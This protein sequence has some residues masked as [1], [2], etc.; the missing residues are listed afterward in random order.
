[1]KPFIQKLLEFLLFILVLFSGAGII[2]WSVN[3]AVRKGGYVS[4]DKGIKHVILGNSMPECAFN[5]QLVS[6]FKNLAQSGE[7]NFYT[8]VKTRQILLNNP[9]V[10]AVFIGI[11]LSL[12]DPK[13]WYQDNEALLWQ[14]TKYAPF[15]EGRDVA[16]LTIRNSRGSAK[17]H[18]ISLLRNSMFLAKN[19]PKS[20]IKD[21]RWGG[22]LRLERDRMDSLIRAMPVGK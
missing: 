15:V 22:Y 9:S 2:I 20:Y 7:T 13:E 11:S 21:M 5:D 14:Y 17:A 4:L 19:A 1:M 10:E 12:L 6:G 3:A 18:V 16:L 8:L